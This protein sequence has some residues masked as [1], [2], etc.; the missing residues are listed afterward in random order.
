MTLDE[1]AVDPDPFGQFA[2][3]YKDA[4]DSG[5]GIPNAF[6]LS[7][8]SADGVPSSRILLLKDFSASGFVFYTNS[9]SRK[10]AE[11]RVNPRA[12]IC[13]FWQSLERQVR[14]EGAIETVDDREADRYF[15][16]RPRESRIG[17]WASPQ[18]EVVSGR[19]ELDENFARFKARFKDSVSIP[20]PPF[21]K[22]YRLVP[23][24]FEFWQGRPN[25]MHDR[26]RYGRNGESDGWAIERV[27]P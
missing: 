2:L 14:I 1:S 18:G 6:A 26:I 5:V 15:A 19:G 11:I 8:A 12:A 16:Q 27:A 7:T 25:R 21:W 3:W 24:V 10:G 23:S 20:R 13:F 17:A 9:R 4:E 22:G